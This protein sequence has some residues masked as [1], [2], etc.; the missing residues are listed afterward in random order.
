MSC[1]SS[2]F[3]P[4]ARLQDGLK[5][6][7]RACH[8]AATRE[9]RAKNSKKINRRTRAAYAQ[10]REAINARRRELYAMRGAA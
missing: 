3:A 1:P 9:W 4:D 5:S 2:A 10:D 8:V 7:C 6:W